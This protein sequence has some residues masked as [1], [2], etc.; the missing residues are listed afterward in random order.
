[1][2]KELTPLSFKRGAGGEYELT[3]LSLKRGA[4]GEY[5]LTPSPNPNP[6]GVS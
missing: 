1:M 6:Q 2:T 3:P 5:E 4:G